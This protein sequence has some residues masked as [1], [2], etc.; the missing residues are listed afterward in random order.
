[1]ALDW[2]KAVSIMEID[3]P[4]SISATVEIEAASDTMVIGSVTWSS[5]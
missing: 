1:M 3:A 4:E 2:A 5:G